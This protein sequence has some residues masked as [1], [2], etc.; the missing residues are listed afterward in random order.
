MIAYVLRLAD[1]RIST[2]YFPTPLPD[3]PAAHYFLL[4][5]LRSLRLFS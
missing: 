5:K 2:V 1:G 3:F 4:Y